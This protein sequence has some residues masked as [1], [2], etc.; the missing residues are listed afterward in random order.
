MPD[1]PSVSSFSS[2]GYGTICMIL[3][4]ALP[5]APEPL[6]A[7]SLGFI[8]IWFFFQGSTITCCFHRLKSCPNAKEIKPKARNRQRVKRAG[9]RAAA[10]SGLEEKPAIGAKTGWRID[11][12]DRIHSHYHSDLLIPWAL[13]SSTLWL[14]SPLYGCFQAQE[15]FGNPSVY[16]LFLPRS[17]W[18]TEE[19]ED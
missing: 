18:W 5:G 3:S 7:C 19:I 6:Y 12:P 14:Y 2:S 1:S 10:Y 11:S 4:Y 15:S 9:R 8:G 13:A 17:G 16:S